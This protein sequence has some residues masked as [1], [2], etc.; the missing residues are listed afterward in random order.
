MDWLIKTCEIILVVLYITSTIV[1][2]R[3]FLKS[4]D[5]TELACSLLIRATLV[6]HIAYLVLLAVT[7]S[8]NPVVNFYEFLSTLALG[9]LAVYLYLEIRFKNRSLGPLVLG[10]ATV[11]K[12]VSV[13]FSTH[14][15][16]TEIEPV[17][18]SGWFLLHQ[19]IL[20][21]GF[22]SLLISA[23]FST[24]YLVLQR[25]LKRK[26]F[27]IFFKRFLPLATLGEMNYQAL[28]TGVILLF[29][30]IPVAFI[31]VYRFNNGAWDFQYCMFF[32]YF[33]VYFAGVLLGKYAGWQGQRL[34]YYSLFSLL[35]MVLATFA[36][37]VYTIRHDWF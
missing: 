20:P 14:P 24:M 21:L 37:K 6:C 36:A 32:T 25:S 34:A 12:V 17:L 27:D 5:R 28:L 23:I 18:K 1:Y 19:V 22:A 15:M 35:L 29:L 4:T 9:L 16:G 10:F 13:I 26:Q 7:T 31:M 11:A 30:N 2:V 8:R 3:D 33:V